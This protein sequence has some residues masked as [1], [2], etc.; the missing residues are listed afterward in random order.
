MQSMSLVIA[1]AIQPSRLPQRI[2]FEV[3]AMMKNVL[4]MSDAGEGQRAHEV[5]RTVAL[6]GRKNDT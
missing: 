6:R 1:S 4:M 2:R 3:R 5:P